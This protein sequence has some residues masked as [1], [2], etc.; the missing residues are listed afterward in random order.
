MPPEAGALCI[1]Y[2]GGLDSTVLLHA[3]A[4]MC[5]AEGS[6]RLRAVHIDHQLQAASGQWREHCAR[7]AAAL[8][9][10][11]LALKVEVARDSHQGLEASARTARYAAL[12]ALLLPGEALLTAHHA[13]DQLETVLLALMRGA[14]LRGMGA[15]PS[16][17]PCGEGW[18]V[19]PLLESTRAEL[20]AWARAQQVRWLDEPSNE[21]LGFDRN[22]LRHRILPLLYQRWPAAP[23]SAARSAAHLGEAERMLDALAAADCAQ[24]ACGTCLRVD[25]LAALDSARRRNVMRHWIRRHDLLAPS[26]RKLATIEHDMLRARQDRNPC[27]QWEGGEIRRYRG[28]LYCLR[29][30]ADLDARQAILWQV[31]RPVAL[32][33]QLGHLRLAAI[34]AAHFPGAAAGRNTDERS[35]GDA[36]RRPVALAVA[37]LVQPLQIRFRSGGESLRPAGDVHRRKLKKLLQS[38]AVLPWWRERLPLIYSDGRLA[39]V[40]DLWIA[41]EFAAE[42]GEPAARIVWQGRPD[43]LSSNPRLR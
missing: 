1:A 13:D 15:M 12:Q 3:A 36:G 22:Y 4:R 39:A 23:R 31:D 33:A 20:E 32:P 19:R 41:Q 28:L 40:G 2:S 26:T 18:L 14:G 24:A 5:A 38:S 10:E 30:R 6:Y 8:Q 17:Q 7:T 42:A 9:V 29:P 35:A 11:F 37:K 25:A 34:E 16:R 43:L 27:V 21:S